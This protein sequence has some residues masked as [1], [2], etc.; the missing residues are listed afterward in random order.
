M[1]RPA[2]LLSLALL[3]A[4]TGSASA[5]A[6]T[7]RL[8]PPPGQLVDVGG[9]RLHLYCTGAGAPTVVIDAGAGSW[10]VQWGWVQQAAAQGGG[11]VCTYDRAGLGWSDVSPRP[12]RTA[13]MA[14]ELHTLLHT[15][16]VAPPLILAGHSLGAWNVRAYQARYPEEVAGLVLLD[17]AH[18]QQWTRLPPIAWQLTKMSATAT[19][20]RAATAAA[21]PEADIA[22]AAF[23]RSVPTFK[24]AYVAS[25]QRGSTYETIAAETELA[26]VSADDV[27]RSRAASLGGLPLVVLSAG[28][29]FGAFAGAPIPRDA[30]NAIWRDLQGELAALSAKTVHIV[31]PKAHHRL[32]ESDAQGAADAIRRA[33]TLVAA[34]PPAPAGLAV[35]GPLLPTTSTPLVDRLLKDLEASYRTKDVNGFVR[36]FTEDFSQLDVNRRVHVRGRSTWADWTRRIND[37]HT[38]MDRIHRGRA[39]VGDWVIVEIEWS[40]TLRPAALGT[41]EPRHYQYTGLGLLRLREGKIHEQLLYG[42]FATFSEQIAGR[43]PGGGSR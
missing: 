20:A 23:L 3:L 15:A 29:S 22:D 41:E 10:S 6:P 9:F 24:D 17:G 26:D 12:R 8:G 38:T 39:V 40:G 2:R 18:E 34:V 5:Q 14:E 36:L 13:V 1:S 4:A 32:Y 27:P 33:M 35:T 43:H 16:G 42:D 28:D 11:T 30:A 37:A 21:T 19:R 25:M 7:A 31:L